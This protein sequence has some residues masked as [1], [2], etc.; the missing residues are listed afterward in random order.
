MRLDKK[1][2][3]K[4]FRTK[5]KKNKNKVSFQQA[6][7]KTIFTLFHC[8]KVQENIPRWRI[9]LSATFHLICFDVIN[10]AYS[11]RSHQRMI[12]WIIMVRAIQCITH[13]RIE[14]VVILWKHFHT[15]KLQPQILDCLVNKVTKPFPQLSCNWSYESEILNSRL[16]YCLLILDTVFSGSVSSSGPL[17]PYG[18]GAGDTWKQ[19][20]CTTGCGNTLNLQPGFPFFGSTMNGL[21]VRGSFFVHIVNGVVLFQV[22][23]PQS[24]FLN[25]LLTS[26]TWLARWCVLLRLVWTFRWSRSHIYVD[27]LWKAI[28][29]LC[30]PCC[31]ID[32]T[33]C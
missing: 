4:I 16:F 30:S 33:K 29:L 12:P 18:E 13:A 6:K 15:I 24:L 1:G 21:R 28:Q 31:M 11:Y 8:G 20:G 2:R 5:A 23:S 9:M 19:N 7:M 10:L 14:D 25:V 22:T 17:Y 3:V 32:R 27:L 26:Y